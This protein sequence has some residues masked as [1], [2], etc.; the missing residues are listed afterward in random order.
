[1]RVT[2]LF[3]KKSSVIRDWDWKHVSHAGQVRNNASLDRP[4]GLSCPKRENVR[5]RQYFLQK[6]F[7]RKMQWNPWA[8]GSFL[9]FQNLLRSLRSCPSNPVEKVG[10]IIEK[11]KDTI[12]G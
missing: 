8:E 7:L 1:M 9:L 3:S 12:E 2:K 5:H 11:R 6:M 10:I 4:A